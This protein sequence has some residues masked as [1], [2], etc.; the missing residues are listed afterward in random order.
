MRALKMIV[1][2]VASIAGLFI[3]S[4]PAAATTY[5]L[6]HPYNADYALWNED[7]NTLVVCDN[8]SG[9]G[10]AV[11]I[12]D[13]IGGTTKHVFDGNGAQAGCGS[14]G[15]LNVDETKSAYLWI[16]ANSTATCYRSTY[17]VP[18]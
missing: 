2:L 4:S 6:D 16:C 9:N 12:L 11:A 1:A 10:T 13:V 7:T 5:R 18:L 3:F 15:S 14:T 17:P 8:S